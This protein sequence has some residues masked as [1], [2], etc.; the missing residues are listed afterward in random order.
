MIP[1]ENRV[2]TSHISGA[3]ASSMVAV[4]AVVLAF[5]AMEMAHV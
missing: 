4:L 5:L 1:N 3:K 2:M